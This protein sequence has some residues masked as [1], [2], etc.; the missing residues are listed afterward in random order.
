MTW[1][2]I[3]KY[4]LWSMNE[5]YEVQRLDLTRYG[6]K[7]AEAIAKNKESDVKL[8]LKMIKDTRQIID[9]IS[10]ENMTVKDFARLVTSKYQVIA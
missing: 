9:D 10:D 7:L 5:F 3:D 2:F 8:Y 6:E 1:D 4:W